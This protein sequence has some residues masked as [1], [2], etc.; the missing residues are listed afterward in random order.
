MFT[1]EGSALKLNVTVDNMMIVPD[2]ES[3]EDMTELIVR[4]NTYNTRVLTSAVGPED[5]P[6]E[7]RIE[8]TGQ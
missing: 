8:P 5:R 2:E 7:W 4:T 3:G 1:G 6:W